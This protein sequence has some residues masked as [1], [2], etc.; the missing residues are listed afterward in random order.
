MTIFLAI[1]IGLATG[2]LS[3]FGIGGGSLLLLYLT[4]FAG[5]SQY[6]AGG[7]NL[8]YF[9][10]CAPAALVSHIKNKLVEWQAVKWGVIAGVPASIFAAFGA[11]MID[12]RWLRRLFGVFLLYV[13]CKELFTKRKKSGTP[14]E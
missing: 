4:L 9:V 5:V 14:P 10:A 2:V 1:L 7:V 8:L 13:G 11:A 12:V 6:R 3:G